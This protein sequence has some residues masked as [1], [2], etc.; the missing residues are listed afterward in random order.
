MEIDT[1]EI[2]FFAR[3][4]LGMGTDARVRDPEALVWRMREI[5]RRQMVL[6]G[7]QREDTV[8]EAS[9]S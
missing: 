3:M 8:D 9:R 7:L 2:E 4:F 1:A 6:Y 5:L